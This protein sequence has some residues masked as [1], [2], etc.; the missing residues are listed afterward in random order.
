MEQAAQECLA[1]RKAKNSLLGFASY[2][3]QDYAAGLH[4]KLIA[5]ALQQVES[6]EIKRLM[7]FLPPRHGKSELVSRKFP[8]WYIGR[9]SQQQII[10]ASYNSDLAT[11]FGRDVRNTIADPDYKN[12][13]KISLAPDSKAADRWITNNGGSYLAAGV[14]SGITGR[15]AHLGII[16]DP[17][18]DRKEAE[19]KTIRDGVWNWYTSTFYTRLMPG[20][21]IILCQTRWHE[22][23]L[24]GRLLKE[25]RRG[26]ESWQIINLPAIAEGHDILG[27][28]E[29]E[30]LWPEW[31]PE[32]TLKQIQNTIGT[33]DWLSL[34]Q[35]R[36]TAE[37]GNIFKKHW[38]RRFRDFPEKFSKRIHAWDTA[39]KDGQ[40]NDFSVCLSIGVNEGDIYI[41][42]RFKGKLE[43]PD[44]KKA[45]ESMA[46]RDKVDAVVVEDKASGQSLVQELRRNTKLS[47]VA[48]KID[49]DKVARAYSVTP[50]IE[51]GRVYL[52]EWG[53]WIDDYIANMASFP[54]AEHDDDVDAT[55][56]GLNY[57][58]SQLTTNVLDMARPKFIML[59]S[60]TGWMGA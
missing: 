6:G 31:Y 55:T 53:S 36:P 49:R 56:V 21:S 7:I 8:A 34:Y 48:H 2:I 60:S 50:M 54:Q 22:D 19:S 35:Q 11:E 42:D 33:Y 38:W 57:L 27:R 23:D 16:D 9:N 25:M 4:H 32:E 13:F 10:S 30:A 5:E 51:G 24:A 17:F 29:G 41:L 20:G 45:A 15:G 44:L 3:K 59:G 28:T 26:G 37:E 39:F 14:G 47:V 40:Q 46:Y 18:K 58:K 52:P 12:I 43:F 1:R